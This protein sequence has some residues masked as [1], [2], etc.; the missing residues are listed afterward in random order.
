MK[1]S[2]KLLALALAASM[3]V[4]AVGCGGKTEK[5]SKM[6]KYEAKIEKTIDHTIYTAEIVDNTMYAS[7]D[8]YDESADYSKTG[9]VVYNFD[10]NEEKEVAIEQNE[11]EE[12]IYVKDIY[13]NSEGNIIA[14]IEVCEESTEDSYKSHSVKNYYNSNL[15]L[16]NSEV[17]ETRVEKYEVDARDESGESDNEYVS[18]SVFSNGKKCSLV[19]KKKEESYVIREYNENGDVETEIQLDSDDYVETVMVLDDGTFAT[20][21]WGNNGFELRKIDFEKK[22]IDEVIVDLSKHSI[23]SIFK[24]KNNTLLFSSNSALYSCNISNNKTEKILKFLDCDIDPDN[25]SAIYQYENSDYGVVVPGD[26]KTDI[27]RLSK[28]ASNAQSKNEITM[29]VLF[30]DYELKEKVLEYNRTSDTTRISI[31]EYFDDDDGDYE[32]A[33]KKFNSDIASGNCPDI[34]DFGGYGIAVEKYAEKGIL[35]DLTPYFEKDPDINLEDMVES[36]VNAYKI[37]GKLYILP[38]AVNFMGLM[39]PTDVVG[40]EHGWTV[41][42]FIEVANSLGDDTE[43]MDYASRENMLYM[44]LYYNID[45]YV[46]WV[47]G[48]CHFD[49][50]DFEKIL[51]LS[52]KYPDMESLYGDM[53]D[54]DVDSSSNEFTKIREGKVLLRNTYLSDVNEYMLSKTMYNKEVTFK[55]IPTSEGNGIGITPTSSAVAISSK[56]KYKDAAWEFIRQLY[57]PQIEE[58]P[59]YVDMYGYPVRKDDLDKFLKYAQKVETYTD[60]NGNEV[61]F[62]NSYSVGDVEIAIPV[63][64]DADIEEIKDIINSAD[65]ITSLDEEIYN[66]IQEETKSFYSGQKSAKEVADVIQSRVSIFVKENK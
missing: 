33:M 27:I 55:G 18:S 1:K 4:T 6:D 12:Y 31:I 47:K 22:S 20:T 9:I 19:Y 59:E 41:D 57:L 44:L 58:N 64:S 3:C 17:G 56:S 66:I 14:E 38:N 36:I 29:G 52:A 13:L 45:Q 25:I 16:I 60:D 35:E 23:N 50:G 24:G 63:P 5:K 26:G 7:Y 39:G 49:D 48:E 11:G 54:F 61:P 42:E 30:L 15:E 51:E 40:K 34:V 37:N 65:T 10:T 53:E 21:L 43:I 32:G 8:D 62:E 2:K 28:S 46:D